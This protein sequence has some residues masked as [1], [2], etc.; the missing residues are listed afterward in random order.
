MDEPNTQVALRGRPRDLRLDDAIVAA[1]LDLL[2]ERGYNGLSLAAVAERAGTTTPAIYRRWPSKADLV[3]HVVFRT[4]GDD[5]IADTGDL[6]ADVRT[7]VRWSL[8]KLGSPQGRAALAGL[9]GEPAGSAGWPPRPV[10]RAVGAPREHL[11]GRR[12][13]WQVRPTSTRTC[14]SR[15]SPGRR[16]WPAPCWASADDEEWVDRLTRAI[17]DG[18]RPRSAPP[19]PDRSGGAR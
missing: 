15:C 11:A 3:L 13:P 5:V 19:V 8:E 2:A 1:T 7:M 12:R 14:S 4:E 9:L 6:E 10:G 18:I 16:C 17:L